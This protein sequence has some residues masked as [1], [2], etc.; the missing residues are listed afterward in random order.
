M[1]PA[2]PAR[3]T[4]YPSSG[5]RNRTPNRELRALLEESEWTQ[6]AFARALARLGAE[7][8]IHL[9]YDRT[10]VAHWLRG[11]RPDPRVR[12]LMAE[13]LSRRLGRRITVADLG[14]NGTRGGRTGTAARAR[15]G[16]GSPR[17][18]S[19]PGDDDA[20]D[21]DTRRR[22]PG[23]DRALSTDSSRSGHARDILP[24]RSAAAGTVTDESTE[25]ERGATATGA[26]T[27]TAAADEPAREHP[28][29][30]GLFEFGTSAHP[31]D[32]LTALT[33]PV[34]PPPRADAP[35]PAPYTLRLLAE[36]VRPSRGGQPAEGERPPEGERVPGGRRAA[37]APAAAPLPGARNS[38]TARGSRP[39][40]SPGPGEVASVHEHA[41]FFA[42]QADRHGG[43]HIRTSLAA[44][45]SGLVRTLRRGEEGAHHR[46]MQA[47]AARL[48]YLL[49]RV[50]ADEHR[51]GLA[52]RAFLTA[53]ELAG[54]AADPEGVALARRA[55]S[56][57]AHQLGHPRASLALA[58]AALAAAPA[59]TDP[60]ARAFLYAGLAVAD[61]ACGARD[62]AL[63]ALGRAE[64]Q[65][66]RAPVDLTTGP[67]SPSG[68]PVGTYQGA[69][70]LY[71][72]SQVRAALGDR[73]GAIRDLRASLH[74][75]PAQERRT[76]ALCQAELAEL[77]LSR[78]RLEEA[79]AT[80]RDFLEVSAH[81]RSG[82]VVAARS[83]IPGL[84]RPYARESRVRSLL[85][86]VSPPAGGEPG[87]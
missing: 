40:S 33:A 46:G 61:A 50:Y 15:G 28:A 8:G 75:R 86:A 71:Q 16:W 54:E 26:A 79:C 80:W 18:E 41:R 60:S 7:V 87:G 68:E 84:L 66:A 56:S 72:S 10:S 23:P 42:L 59:D 5:S 17:T 81:V 30:T 57:Q 62:R 51:H 45:L 4:A 64:R 85:V 49:A 20:S 55:L 52:Q 14:M 2:D 13:A 24:H 29:D 31:A 39:V 44:Y 19:E 1:S 38:C 65:L 25:A 21:S 78:G 47:G 63:D 48:S 37:G 36:T 43:G 3:A 77:L 9:R 27:A 22:Q 73:E 32:Q 11:S 12:Y 34:V 82:R 53:A 6:A 83:R 69:A 74:S 76:R 58:E 35:P 67:E 70:L